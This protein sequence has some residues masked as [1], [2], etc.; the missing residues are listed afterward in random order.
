VWKHLDADSLARDFPDAK[1][2][3]AQ[4]HGRGLFARKGEGLPIDELADSLKIQGYL[5]PD[6][7]SSTLVE[8]LKSKARGKVQTA[9]EMGNVLEDATQYG[10]GFTPEQA[11]AFQ[12][13]KAMRREQ[14]ERFEQGYND[15]LARGV[16]RE[17]DVMGN[18]F[19]SGAAGASAAQ[20]FLRSV[21]ND[22]RAR[23][24]MH[25][26]VLGLFLKES[27]DAAGKFS[28][29]KMDAFFKRYDAALRQFPEIS[30]DLT[31]LAAQQAGADALKETLEATGKE[32]ARLGKSV[33]KR[34]QKHEAVLVGR[35]VDDKLG[36]EL[37]DKGLLSPAEVERLRA[38]TKSTESAQ[39]AVNLAKVHGS[40]TAQNLATQDI[41]SNILGDNLDRKRNWLDMALTVPLNVPLSFFAKNFYGDATQ[42]I[43][44][45][46]VRAAAD[47]AYAKELL[48]MGNVRNL[49]AVSEILGDSAKAQANINVRGLLGLLDLMAEE[50]QKKKK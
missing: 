12:K 24:A 14:G 11:E 31:L 47:P 27:R 50:E 1:R 28:T 3:V 15:P 33:L 34:N 29:S 37:V 9:A 42:G 45:H 4:L 32:S 19:K 6:A 7:D 16:M 5:A 39:N 38:L 10:R 44:Q 41:L 49:K 22:S 18:Y 2:E 46:L 23:N 21:G 48:E 20:D 8:L 25:D 26:Y 13:A 17:A 40:P 36:K 43:K 35:K 30:D